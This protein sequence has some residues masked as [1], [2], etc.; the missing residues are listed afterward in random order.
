MQGA[1]ITDVLAASWQKLRQSWRAELHAMPV[2]RGIFFSGAAPI[3]QRPGPQRPFTPDAHAGNELA[4]GT[5]SLAGRQIHFSHVEEA[6][7]HPAP[8]R[9]FARM[10]HVFCWLKDLEATT[11]TDRPARLM[12]AHAD[13]WITHFGTWNRFSWDPQITAE[14]CMSWL[15]VA[16]QMFAGDAVQS[17]RRLESLGRQLRYLRSVFPVMTHN[18]SRMVAAIALTQAGTCLHGLE[19]LKRLGLKGLREELN[20][21][22]LPDGGHVSRNPQLSARL[23]LELESLI[24]LLEQHDGVA[25]A[26]LHKAQDRLIPFVGFARLPSGQMSPFHGAG[27]ADG[28]AISRLLGESRIEVKDFR[29][30]HHSGYHRLETRNSALL[31]DCGGMPPGDHGLDAHA[32]SGAFVFGAKESPI[33][34]NCGAHTA[35]AP[36]WEAASRTTAA[37]S[38]LVLDDTSSSRILDGGLMGMI[39]G[40]RALNRAEPRPGRRTEDDQGVWLET[41]HHEYVDRY[42]LVHGRRLFLD[43]AGTHLRGEDTLERPVGV[44]RVRDLHPIPFCIRFHLHPD[45]RA[46]LSRGKDSALILLP[47]GKGWK[48]H[49]DRPELQL[50]N[51][52]Y[53][54]AGA[55]PKR[56]WQL[57][58]SGAADPNGTGTEDSNRVRW[59]L[60][61]V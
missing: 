18:Y 9:T 21:Q 50:E 59:S 28:P 14:R 7:T 51:S 11:E 32:S 25:P 8:S 12:Q 10:Q 19:S 23:A 15:G 43:H 45:V 34:V 46:S 44:D 56:T 37:H 47:G 38:T 61:R 53:L 31:L 26:Y 39:L 48:F 22:I 36:A 55:P 27:D 4:N 3:F 24:A 57:V 29:I 20:A 33:I 1:G 6:W 52:I 5:L 13:A 30:A 2:Y 16:G 54:A 40:P 35:H 60:K 49:S 42:G 58:I 41:R 17:S